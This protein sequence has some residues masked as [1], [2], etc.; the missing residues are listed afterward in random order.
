MCHVSSNKHTCQVDLDSVAKW[1]ADTD[2]TLRLYTKLSPA[3]F[4]VRAWTL[5]QNATTYLSDITVSQTS[6]TSQ[7]QLA[8]VSSR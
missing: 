1:M 2:M 8:T 6:L 7:W 4:C 3:C 5:I